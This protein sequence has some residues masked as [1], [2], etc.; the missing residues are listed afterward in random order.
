[1]SI[2][3]HRASAIC[4]RDD[5]ILALHH[6]DPDGIE[7]WGVPGGEIED[8]E[9]PLEAALRET[10]EETGYRVEL[11]HDP[12]LVIEYEFR[13]KRETHRCRT[14]WFAV[15]PL[16]GIEHEPHAGDQDYLTELR[17]IPI[18]QWHSL[19]VGYPVLQDAVETVLASVDIL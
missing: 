8:G 15:R 9:S 7:F 3:R 5:R 12:E 2:D 10:R 6:R 19:F 16:P 18:D 14:H 13:W 17:W 1:M 4:L 11:L